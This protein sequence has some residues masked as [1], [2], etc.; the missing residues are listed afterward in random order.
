MAYG[1]KMVRHD[2]SQMDFFVFGAICIV[3]FYVYINK[4][5]ENR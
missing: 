1:F 4:A 5:R 3:S 2:K